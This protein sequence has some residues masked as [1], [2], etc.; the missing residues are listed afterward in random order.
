MIFLRILPFP[1]PPPGTGPSVSGSDAR[2]LA[3]CYLFR[4]VTRSLTDPFR[5]VTSGELLVTI[6]TREAYSDYFAADIYAFTIMEHS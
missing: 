2:T 3:N 5:F 4:S 1:R 6:K